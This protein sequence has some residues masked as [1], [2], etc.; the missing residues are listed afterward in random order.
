MAGQPLEFTERRK[1]SDMSLKPV[2]MPTVEREKAK[3]ANFAI[4]TTNNS[5]SSESR[6]KNPAYGRQMKQRYKD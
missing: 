4:Y 6:K 1:P 5:T 3:N 2:R